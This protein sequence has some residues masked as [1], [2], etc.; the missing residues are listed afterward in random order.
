MLRTRFGGSRDCCTVL[1]IALSLASLD[2]PWL[3]LFILLISS[4]HSVE[5]HI[6]IESIPCKSRASPPIAKLSTYLPYRGEGKK[7]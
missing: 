5:R 2:V 4:F 7:K 1:V 6:P 3:S